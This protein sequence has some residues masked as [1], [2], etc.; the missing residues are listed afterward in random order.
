MTPRAGGFR[1][2]GCGDD[3]THEFNLEDER[4]ALEGWLSDDF[5][6][7]VVLEV[8]PGGSQTDS[9]V[10]TTDGEAGPTL[11]SA[12]TVREVTSRDN[13]V[14]PVGMRL[15]PRPNLVVTGVRAFWAGRLVA[16]SGRRFQV[17]DVT[18]CGVEPTPRCVVPARDP[19]TGVEYDGFGETFIEK[20]EEPSPP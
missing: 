19:R 16:D 5:G 13:G 15:R 20:R 7:P 8:G 17:G 12:A 10:F 14:D 4:E 11:I 2:R 18:L 1:V 3:R 9:V 6:M